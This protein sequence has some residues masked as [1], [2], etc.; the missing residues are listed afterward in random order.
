MTCFLFSPAL[1]YSSG[2]VFWV[3][4]VFLFLFH[5]LSSAHD[6]LFLSVGRELNVLNMCLC[7][8]S[9]VIL[10]LYFNAKL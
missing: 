5:A 3:N 1:C 9:T 4:T 10:S 6:L 8:L 7:E 2:T